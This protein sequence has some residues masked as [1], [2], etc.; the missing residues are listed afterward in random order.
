MV[1][2]GHLWLATGQNELICCFGKISTTKIIFMTYSDNFGIISCIPWVISHELSHLDKN[3]HWSDLT[4]HQLKPAI[5]RAC[6]NKT[7]D[8]SNISC[9][10]KEVMC[11]FSIICLFVTVHFTYW[12]V[13]SLSWPVIFKSKGSVLVV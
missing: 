5:F 13:V 10:F 2:S 3:D 6:N 8:I 11:D 12:P 9:L 7:F 1:F 4:D